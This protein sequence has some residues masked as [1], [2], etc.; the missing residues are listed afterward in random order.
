MPVWAGIPADP[1]RLE[2][3]WLP[4]RRSPVPASAASLGAGLT[5]DRRTVGEP[6][7]LSANRTARRV[8]VISMHT[9]PTA[10]L[11]QNANGGLNVYV[12]EI[13]AAFS[14]RGIASDVFTRRGP[15]DPGMESLAPNSCVIYLP[16]GRGI[17]KYDLYEQVPAFANQVFAFAQREGLAYDMLF[18][19][20][21]LSGEVACLLTP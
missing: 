8:A 5:R 12:R 15:I 20:Y 17:D 6:T 18:S 11:G 7:Q 9:S 19:H 10:S 13:C 2:P 1:V 16:A 14:D 3:I 21:W 4:V